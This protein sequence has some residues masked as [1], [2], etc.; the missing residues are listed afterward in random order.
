MYINIRHIWY[1]SYSNS[2]LDKLN[3][4]IRS[5]IYPSV[6]DPFLSIPPSC[7]HLIP[8]NL[9]LFIHTPQQLVCSVPT[10]R[11]RRLNVID[12]ICNR[13][14]NIHTIYQ[15]SSHLVYIICIRIWIKINICIRSCLYPSVSDTFMCKIGF[16]STSFVAS[17]HAKRAPLLYTLTCYTY[18]AK[19]PNPSVR[20]K[21][22]T[23]RVFLPARWRDRVR[24]FSRWYI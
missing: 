21:L 20:S 4:C 22:Q 18:I 15:Y 2:N 12:H 16:C 19:K 11:V 8:T 7:A 23:S 9:I 24:H 17:S 1:Y 3:I 10:E 14:F 6:F 5:C 13:I